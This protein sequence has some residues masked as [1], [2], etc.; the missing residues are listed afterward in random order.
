MDYERLFLDHLGLVEQVVGFVASRQRLTADEAEE[1]SSSIRMKLLENDYDVLRRFEGRSSF[2][3]YLTAVVSRV[4]LDAR[5]A[6]WGKWR[7]SAQA[8]RFGAVGVLLDQ[9]LTRDGFSTDEAVEELRA[10]GVTLPNDQLRSM[11]AQLPGRIK[12]R[13]VGE[14]ALSSLPASPD[15]HLDGATGCSE[16]EM[17]ALESALAGCLDELPDEDR[18]ILK[19]RFQ[20]ELTVARIAQLLQV[21][22]KSLY[23]R[24]EQLLRRL[25]SD[26]EARGVEKDVVAR[27]VGDPATDLGP[28][29]DGERARKS[30]PSPSVVVGR[31][32]RERHGHV[33]RLDG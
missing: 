21:E 22:Q 26:L 5:I 13:L 1:L 8:R 25:R 4:A 3:T 10:R 20:Q 33:E 11:A 2:K 15:T 29:I 18:L 27:F 32:P 28:L 14:D 12:K 17:E 31:L 6:R 30:P 19:W 9:L 7:P 23:R 24:I 16:T